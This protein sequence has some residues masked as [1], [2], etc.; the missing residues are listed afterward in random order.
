MQLR[1]GDE[2]LIGC[3]DSMSG[4]EPSLEVTSLSSGLSLHIFG[5]TDMRWVPTAESMLD[6]FSS[7]L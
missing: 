1:K 6:I 7:L 4:R 5:V 3:P 2:V